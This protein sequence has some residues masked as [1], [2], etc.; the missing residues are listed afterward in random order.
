[1]LYVQIFERKQFGKSPKFLGGSSKFSGGSSK[2]LGGDP[3]FLGGSPKFLDRVMSASGG[4][5]NA[6]SVRTG[7]KLFFTAYSLIEV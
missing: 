3:I 7:S 2:F 4:A 1:L 5:A 6:W